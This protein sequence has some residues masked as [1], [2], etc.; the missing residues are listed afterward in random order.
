MDVVVFGDRGLARLAASALRDDSPHRPVAFTVHGSFLR[1]RMVDGLPVLPFESL[2]QHF[3]PDAA[4]MLVPLGWT[5][6]GALRAGVVAAARSRGYRLESYVSSR[7][8][9]A[10]GVEIGEHALVF[11]GAIV[12]HGARIG[13]DCILRA[14]AVVAHDAT[15]GDHCFVAPR[16]VIGGTARVAEC[17]VLGAQATVVSGVSV[18]RRCFVAAGAVVTS[19]TQP[20]GIYRGNPARR[21][22]VTV[23][24]FPLLAAS[25]PAG[26]R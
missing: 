2:E 21:A 12:E 24:R 17:C 13:A 10:R 5:G 18:A 9:V 26:G 1:E 19:D 7:A 4:G 11:D 23:D 14:G 6:L 15:V 3:P 8:M 16:A 25:A 20:D 22:R